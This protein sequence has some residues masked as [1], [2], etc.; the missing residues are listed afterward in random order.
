MMNRTSQMAR[1]TPLR[2]KTPMKQRAA[3]LQGRTTPMK[4]RG[5]KGASVTPAQKRFHDQLCRLV[6]CIACRKD[7]RFT[8][9]CSVHH[10]DGRTKPTAH[11]LVIGLCA[12]HHQDGTGAQGLVAVHPY[13]ARFEA[14]YGQQEVLLL[15]CLEV[16][17]RQHGLLWPEPMNAVH[18]RLRGAPV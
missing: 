1:R 6:G 3:G 11:W 17:E 18:A 14:R 13:K 12:G 4:S 16:L 5:M 8:D 7:G 10:L 15:E 9:Q 2:Q